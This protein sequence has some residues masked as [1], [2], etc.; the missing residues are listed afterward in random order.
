[1][2]AGENTEWLRGELRRLK[3]EVRSPLRNL[4]RG[5]QGGQ[6]LFEFGH[7]FDQFRQTLSVPA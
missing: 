6:L 5:L 3:S 2:V 4:F 1:M 7:A